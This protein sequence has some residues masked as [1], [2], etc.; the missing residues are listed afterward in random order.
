LSV[1]KW[2]HIPFHSLTQQ[3]FFQKI[4]WI[5]AGWCRTIPCNAYDSAPS[6]N[7]A[8]ASNPFDPIEELG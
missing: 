5:G 7:S 4:G 8:Y 3:P 6:I 1:P 2:F